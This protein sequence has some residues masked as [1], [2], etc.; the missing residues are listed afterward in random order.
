MPAT[1]YRICPLCEAACNLAVQV[2]GER[3]VATSG[4][5]EDTFS[6]GHVCPKGI[7]LPELHNDPSRLTRPLVRQGEGHVEVSWDEAFAHAAAGLTGV[8]ERHGSESVAVYL[9]N[10]TVHNFGLTLGF[11]ELL[12]ALSPGQIYSA[13]SVDQLPKNLAS[14]LMFG[15]GN[16]VPVPDIER[17]DC[18][19]VIGANP[20]VSNGSLWIVPGFRRHVAALHARG[21]RLV[22]IDP[23]QSETARI[24]DLHV[25]PRPGTDAWLLAA[26]CHS[27]IARGRKPEVPVRGFDA[28]ATVL[29]DFSIERAAVRCGVDAAE[30]ENLVTT[31]VQA[32]AP[33]VYGRVGTTLPRHGTLTSFLIECVNVLTGQLDHPGGAMFPEQAWVAPPR[34]RAAQTFGRFHS[35]VHHYPEVMGELPVAGLADEIETEGPGR[36][37]AMVTI[38]GNPAVSAPDSAR[39]QRALGSLEFLVAVDLYSNETTRHA[40][41]ILPGTSPF[42]DSHYDQFLGSMGYRNTARYSPPV[43]SLTDRPDEWRMML[44]FAFAVRNGRPG[45][46]DELDALED[47]V[48]SSAVRRHVEADGALAGRDVD[49]LCQAIG[50]TRGMERLLDLGVR[51]GPWGDRFGEQDGIALKDMIENPHSIDQGPPRS[52]LS[53]VV[54]FEDGCID[55]APDAIVTDLRT[56]KSEAPSTGLQLIGRRNIQTNNSWLHNLPGLGKGPKRCVLD[57]HPADAASRGIDDGDEVTIASSAGSIV[58]TV[59]LNGDMRRDTV[60]LP[61]GFSE[62]GDPSQPDQRRGPNSNVLS[63]SDHLDSISG[64]AAMNGIPVT[65]VRGGS[66][67]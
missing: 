64:T 11:G 46:D 56:L 48:V 14:I 32:G 10:P 34:R 60:V 16:A 1:S 50:P 17:S 37:R 9:G 2:D 62:L 6:R 47:E 40:D 20:V 66:P 49:E 61:H 65:V 4:D 28:L 24:A 42:N 38:A 22:V 25:A 18:L 5:C 58:A 3:I 27:L 30:I 39:I 51:A 57:M 67:L 53:E 8:R 31:L 63:P 44:G 41:V 29:R 43:L 33:A 36:I 35:R 7:A 23:R 45:A 19:V 26:V 55:L 54:L 12:R 13:G 21:G 59:R 52:R 15:N